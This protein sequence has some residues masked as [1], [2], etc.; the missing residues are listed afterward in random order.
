MS[1]RDARTVGIAEVGTRTSIEVLTAPLAD[2][3]DVVGGPGACP[4]ALAVASKA[5]RGQQGEAA[6]PA[7]DEVSRPMEAARAARAA[8]AWPWLVTGWCVSIRL[9]GLGATTT[10][11]AWREYERKH[12]RLA[13]RGALLVHRTRATLHGGLTTFIEMHQRQWAQM[14]DLVAGFDAHD[15]VALYERLVWP[16]RPDLEAIQSELRCWPRPLA[17]YFGFLT[18]TS[19][20]ATGQRS[21]PN[22]PT[23]RQGMAN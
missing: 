6:P 17:Y 20:W 11:V 2:F 5:L 10:K 19:I 8:P 22:W 13:A 1:R 21:N 3:R 4:P 7:M 14:P 16:P 18:P 9:L 23:S 15:V 12:R